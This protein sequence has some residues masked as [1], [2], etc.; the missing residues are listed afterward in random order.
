[1]S[2]NRRP[3]KC[4]SQRYF[5]PQ[6]PMT[7]NNASAF[8]GSREV[9]R[10][11]PSPE[12]EVL[13]ISGL[14]EQ[15][16][17]NEEFRTTGC[18]AE[19]GDVIWREYNSWAFWKEII[20]ELE[21]NELE[22][23]FEEVLRVIEK[24]GNLQ[25]SEG[26]KRGL[27]KL[28]KSPRKAA[29]TAVVSGQSGTIGK[30][31]GTPGKKSVGGD[32][33][34]GGIGNVDP[35]GRPGNGSQSDTQVAK[36]SSS[37][38]VVTTDSWRTVGKLQCH[39]E[40]IRTPSKESSSGE[41]V[42]TD[43]AAPC[44]SHE[45]QNEEELTL[46]L[47]MEGIHLEESSSPSP[48]H[49]NLTDLQLSTKEIPGTKF[50]I[51]RHRKAE[52]APSRI[53]DQNLNDLLTGGREADGRRHSSS[54]EQL[55]ESNVLRKVASLTLD[56]ATLDQ[57]VTRPKFV[58]EK[59]D[60]QLYEKFEGQMLVNWL[61]SAFQ[62]EGYLKSVLQMTDWK[63]I[64]VQFCTHLLA[65]GVLRQLP[66]KDAPPELVFRPDLMYYWSHTETVSVAPPTPGRL[67]TIS[68]PPPA[69]APPSPDPFKSNGR[70][71][72]IHLTVELLNI[73]DISEERSCIEVETEMT[74]LARKVNEQAKI[75]EDSNAEIERLHQEIER[76]KTL[77]DIQALTS[78]VRADFGSPKK[79]PSRSD[80]ATSTSSTALS[81]SSNKEV[82]C[83][84]LPGFNPDNN[85]CDLVTKT[86]TAS[87]IRNDGA[88]TNTKEIN[89]KLRIDTG[90]NVIEQ[91][92]SEVDEAEEFYSLPSVSVDSLS[93]GKLEGAD[94]SKSD[95]VVVS[96]SEV[97]SRGDD[98]KSVGS[99]VEMESSSSSVSVDVEAKLN[100]SSAEGCQQV[101]TTSSSTASLVTV[102]SCSVSPVV[103]ATT[104]KAP[105][106]PP[107]PLPP[108]MDT[109]VPPPPPMD[110]FVPPPPPPMEAFV[111]PP[112]PPMMMDNGPPPP[113][114]PPFEMGPPGPPPPPFP[115]MGPPPPPPPPGM[116]PPPPP[117]P[118]G[119]MGPP[120][121]PPPCSN[122][123]PPPP[124]PP[125]GPGP[126]PPPPP[127][128]A[129][130]P[131]SPAP[132]PAPPVGGWNAQ[133]S[134][135][136]K[137]PLVPPRSYETSVLDESG[138]PSE[139]RRGRKS[140]AV[141]E[142]IKEPPV[143]EFADEFTQLFSRQVIDRKNAKKKVVKPTKAEVLK[144]LESKRSQ[145]VGILSSSLHLDFSEIENAIY[146][147]DTTVVNLESLQQI[148]DVRATEQ[149]LEA[150]KLAQQSRPDL[151]LDKPEQFLLELA[152][153]PHFAE[154][155]AC[156]MFQAEFNDNINSI[157]S[158]LN[159][160]KSICQTL[161]SSESLKSVLAIILALG[162][163]MNG[164]NRQRGQ[165]DGFGLEILPR[166]RDVKSTDNSITLLHYIV[167][168]YIKQCGDVLITEVAAPVPEPSDIDRAS[169]VQFD[170]SKAQIDKLKNDLE[171][172][173]IKMEKVTSSSEE[174]VQ[175]FKEK[176]ETFLSSAEKQIQEAEENLE[177]CKQR[178]LTVLKAYRFQ[179]KGGS[180]LQEVSPQDFF[181]C[182][183]PFCS[184]FKD[185][186]KKEQQR[187]I[188][189]KLQESK[190]K[191]EQRKLLVKKGKKG[192]GGLKSQLS[193]IGEKIS[194]NTR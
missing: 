165:A 102:P 51:V 21:D 133:R 46:T 63:I 117:P 20:H 16:H 41:S 151:A 30:K 113:P 73:H 56:R 192:E 42:F 3:T 145:N 122:G 118:P 166:L 121:P 109:F 82:Q 187:Y 152:E 37:H 131:G 62:N 43:P 34:S 137:Q 55:L 120:P 84:I 76:S 75:I 98:P 70:T 17:V 45:D 29:S 26:G 171:G 100:K 124:L 184:D 25:G 116:G 103:S 163:F 153:I 112:P 176:M 141:W 14:G 66:D 39:G 23:R 125:G 139:R 74:E 105:P 188:K 107:P 173:K 31:A 134:L 71:S 32:N 77:G 40:V 2:C 10:Q 186:W 135:F 65:A 175:P 185:L 162:N 96:K 183:A 85:D 89:F 13:S 86:V 93:P 61:I 179:P 92:K 87:D 33:G 194:R 115:G 138:Y 169:V 12:K 160:L 91:R 81:K 170:D 60:F 18:C 24:M 57:K 11:S 110:A 106:P 27:M 193:K 128:M 181:P 49:D 69:S 150:I 53:S 119:M 148:Y 157:E 143:M 67:S 164:G 94:N 97:K 154:R 101:S 79:D 7:L 178:F 38:L 108:P 1:M 19:D 140:E 78:K 52:L 5:D 126:P 158:K 4:C 156:F 54:S 59:L 146:N 155:I 104:M 172:C 147:F 8:Q 50:T 177:D 190:R 44:V 83:E 47:T 182:W 130:P 142:E 35:Y 123:I 88:G 48:S 129:Q 15:V 68:W 127:G 149:E 114:P 22:A 64:I 80:A 6:V 168:R 174:N 180:T 111:P 161:V 159:N 189:E 136:R 132:L 36:A 90:S 167:R 95:L 9:C 28:K 99:K 72:G 144:V 58:P 191:Q